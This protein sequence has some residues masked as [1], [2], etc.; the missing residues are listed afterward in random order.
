MYV[1]IDHFLIHYLVFFQI[2]DQFLRIFFRK[3]IFSWKHFLTAESVIIRSTA[4]EKSVL[5]GKVYKLGG[6]ILLSM[7]RREA[8]QSIDSQ[9]HGIFA[10]SHG[11]DTKPGMSDR[12]NSVVRMDNVNCFLQSVQLQRFVATSKGASELPTR[13]L[14]HQGRNRTSHGIPWSSRVPWYKRKPMKPYD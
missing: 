12:C 3:D 1:H 6:S 10:N 13:E 7:G 5:F 4:A 9:L 2:I 8:F 11:V 14:L